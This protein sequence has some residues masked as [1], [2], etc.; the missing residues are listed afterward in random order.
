M[1]ILNSRPKTFGPLMSSPHAHG[2]MRRAG[3]LSSMR[4]CRASL[5]CVADSRPDAEL[6][7]LP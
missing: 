5:S 3:R 2:Q 7:R 6:D 1:I 4:I